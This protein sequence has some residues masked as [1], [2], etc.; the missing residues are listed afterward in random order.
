MTMS[1]IKNI[2]NKGPSTDPCGRSDVAVIS[3]ELRLQNSTLK[4]LLDKYE[5]NLV[6][7]HS[8]KVS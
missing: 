7:G 2:N 4:I 6:L 5:L 3:Q 8:F 1:Y